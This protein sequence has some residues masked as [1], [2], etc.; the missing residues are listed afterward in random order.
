MQLGIVLKGLPK[1]SEGMLP[2]KGGAPFS[3]NSLKIRTAT[4]SPFYLMNHLSV[5]SLNKLLNWALDLIFP[6]L[7]PFLLSSWLPQCQRNLSF[8]RQTPSFTHRDILKCKSLGG[9]LMQCCGR[10]HATGGLYYFK[11]SHSKQQGQGPLLEVFKDG[12]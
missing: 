10:W 2:A 5:I 1:L 9:V 4:T 6:V 7:C 12:S 11:T 3:S 8:Q